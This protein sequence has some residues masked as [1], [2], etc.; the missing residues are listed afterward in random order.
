MPAPDFDPGFTG[1]TTLYETIMV[2]IHGNVATDYDEMRLKNKFIFAVVFSFVLLWLAWNEASAGTIDPSF[3]FRS[4]ETDHFVIHF[5]Q[6]TEELGKR[7]AHLAEDIHLRLSTDLQWCPMEKTQI[8]VVD[9]TDFANG[10]ATV[11]PYN[12]IYIFPAP[13]LP[14]SIIGEYDD[15]LETVILHEYAHILTMDP[16]RGYSSVMRKI[17]GKPLPGYDLLSLPLFLFAAP[18][19]VFMPYWWL[20]GIAVW[21]ETEYGSMG[22]GRSTY[23]EMIY[24]MAVRENALPPVGQINGDVPFW[25]SGHM[26][27]IYGPL[28]KK[29]VAEKY[30]REAIGKISEAHAGRVPFFITGPAR[31]L[32]GRNYAY[33]YRDA[34]SALREDQSRKIEILDSASVTDCRVLPVEGEILT[35]PRMSPDNRFLAVSRKDPNVHE[36]ILVLDTDTLRPI[37]TIEKLPSDHN[38]AWSPDS[39]RIFFTQGDLRGGFNLYQDIYEYGLENRSLKRISTNLRAKD[40]DVSPDGLFLV[41]VKVGAT[42]QGLAVSRVE[43]ADAAEILIDLEN[44]ALSGPK[45]SPDG[46]YIV[47]SARAGKETSID[48][49]DMRS[50]TA[51]TVIK[52]SSSNLYPEWSP[53]GRFIVFT[54]DRT[55]VYNLFAYALE[56]GEVFQITH[57]LGGAFT[58]EVTADGRLIFAGYNSKG[59]HLAEMP[60]DPSKWSKKY[61]PVVTPSWGESRFDP[62][63]GPV[64]AAGDQKAAGSEETEGEPYSAG[65]TLLPRFWL[66]TL[67]SDG[68]GLVVGAFT[69]G[70]DVL[71]YH[72]YSLQAAGGE[73]GEFYFD[74]DYGYDRWYPEFFL[75]G[76]SVPRFYA[77]F[78]SDGDNYSERQSG[79][80]AG[81]RVPLNY[82]ESGYSF[83]A[84]C[85]LRKVKPITSVRGRRVDGFGVYEGRRDSIFLG[86]D[87]RGALRYPYSVSK[88]EGRNVSLLCH[89]YAPEFA[90]ELDQREYSADYEEFVRT[91]SHQVLYLNL[92]GAVSG[93]GVIAQQ[94]FQLGGS[95]GTPGGYPLRGF[96]S[97]FKTGK[98]LATGTLEYRFPIVYLLRGWST[99]PFFWDRL[100]AAAFLDAGHVWGHNK[101]FSW[102]DVSVGAG[103]EAR[104]DMVLG[105]KLRITP[106]LGVARGLTDNGETQVYLVIRVDL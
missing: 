106:S 60:Y 67:S 99:K 41:F 92:R 96:P 62:D 22:R 79:L 102:D 32:T 10:L 87:Y 66:P 19:N 65:D 43:K 94:A 91:W 69:A 16:A 15:W 23:Y 105:Y 2:G 58:P 103:A 11:L 83:V 81:V 9:A 51:R 68:D 46:Q 6:G 85:H 54:S 104:F 93:G 18:P 5:H 75:R 39:K 29:Y 64:T 20:E 74:A 76:Y 24:R 38:M 78:F 61:S 48:L 57:L 3:R 13:P 36:A 82:L 77:E 44:G 33:L 8:V 89:Y 72:R 100:H 70:Q 45:W 34:I 53:D 98:Y 1:V 101:D 90:G 97:A 17:F 71:G 47:Y 49:F 35:N 95:T 63:P 12:A 84:G 40:V 73:G 86:L 21:A 4:V 37:E 52:D 59:F 88:E 42:T 26:P 55:G 50:K 56:S 25:P 80:A 14:D 28:I 31:R 30:G 7:C 27:Y